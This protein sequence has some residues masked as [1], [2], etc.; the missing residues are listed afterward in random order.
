MNG[1]KKDAPPWERSHMRC[2]T[3]AEAFE[4]ELFASALA[5]VGSDHGCPA[6]SLDMV[7]AIGIA[8]SECGEV[9]FSASDRLSTRFLTP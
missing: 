5:K 1:A 4:I 3:K 9:L 6:E 2:S 8:I 7:V